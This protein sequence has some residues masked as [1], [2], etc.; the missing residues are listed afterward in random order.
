MKTK[1]VTKEWLAAQLAVATPER[2]QFIIGRALLA[3]YRNQTGEEQ[4]RTHTRFNNGIGFSKPDA[5]TGSIGA[6][7]FKA[8]K[9]EQWVVDVWMKEASDGKPRI[10][11][12][13]NQLNTIAKA[14]QSWEDR[15]DRT[16]GMSIG[17]IVNN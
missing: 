9:M 5:R 16:Q 14:K 8:G 13:A 2:K 1:I 7:M 6:R 10:C 15:F 11:K 12:Y 3:I 17:P 4:S